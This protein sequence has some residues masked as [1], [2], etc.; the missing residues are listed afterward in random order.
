MKGYL[1]TTPNI[2]LTWVTLLS[3]HILELIECL[4]VIRVVSSLYIVMRN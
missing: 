1:S 2:I 3:H 4:C